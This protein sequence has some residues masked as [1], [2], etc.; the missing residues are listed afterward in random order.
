MMWWG[1][2]KSAS[3]YFGYRGRERRLDSLPLPPNRT[4][5]FPAS[6]S[7]V[8]GSPPRGLTQRRMGLCKREQPLLRKESIGPALMIA[9]TP[10]PATAVAALLENAAQAH[11]D[12][13]VQRLKR[14]VVAVFEICQPAFRDPIDARDDHLQAL[15]IVAPGQ[16]PDFVF[17]LL[18]ALT[19][20]PSKS[21]LE[22]IPEKVEAAMFSGIHNPGLGWMQRQAKT[23]IVDATKH[24]G[25]DFLGYH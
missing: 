24:G 23:R 2:I 5:G 25:F 15:P 11:P 1:A 19:P 9:P 14:R 18:Q 7:P 8:G 20:R 6:G 16:D 13:L 3:S 22:V 10:S 4:G 12:P 17:Q 21:A